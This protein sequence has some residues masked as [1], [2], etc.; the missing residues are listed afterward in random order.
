MFLD[1]C[2][3]DY[4]KLYDIFREALP[5]FEY[6]Y[7]TEVTLSQYEDLKALAMHRGGETADLFRELDHWVQDC[8]FTENVF[9]ICGI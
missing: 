2:C 1:A 4:L 7:V 9:T 5:H 8:Y 6:Y 3:F